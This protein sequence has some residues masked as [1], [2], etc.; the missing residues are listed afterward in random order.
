MSLG[1]AAMAAGPLVGGGLIT[2]LGWRSVF[3]VSVPIGLA[4]MWMAWPI[5]EPRVRPSVHRFDPVGQAAALVA[6]GAPIAV[7]IQ[8]RDWGAPLVASVLAAAA[9]AAALF[10]VVEAR[11]R[12]PMLPLSMFRSRVFTGSTVV[13]AISA[14]VFYGLLFVCGLY[15]Q[16][17]RGYP[18]LRAGLAL[19]PLTATVALGGLGSARAVRVFGGR[20]SMCAA[21]GLYAVGALGLLV[22]TRTSG[23]WPALV[24]M[25]VI[26]LAGGF[27][28]PAATA[29]ALGTVDP[30]RAGIAAAALNTARQSGSAVGVAAFGLLITSLHPFG[31]ALSAVLW[32]IALASLAAAALW[33]L[34]GAGAPGEVRGRRRR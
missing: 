7:L 9:A 19:L 24:P 27:I 2:A 4:G 34:I 17:I 14:F 32:V 6:L 15:F 12:H 20:W 10:L 26:G 33:A 16:Q 23:Y 5:A 13:S 8:G 31:T 30:T 1:G 22:A 29:P 28:S 21:F 25:L 3:F 11:G 18:P